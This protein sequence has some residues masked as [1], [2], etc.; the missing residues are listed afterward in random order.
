MEN[1]WKAGDFERRKSGGILKIIYTF[2][3]SGLWS[4]KQR[5]WVSVRDTN[6][7]SYRH[8][9]AAYKNST[10][11]ERVR[12]INLDHGFFFLPCCVFTRSSLSFLLCA[13]VCVCFFFF[14][15]CFVFAAVR[16]NTDLWAAL[17]RDHL[18]IVN[19]RSV[20]NVF[21]KSPLDNTET[22]L[23]DLQPA[24]YTRLRGN[25]L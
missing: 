3:R 15:F 1:A 9:A 12:G 6:P 18:P 14:L 24:R 5:G 23:S 22:D 13:C 11:V 4:L 16:T 17:I 21:L 2:F 20:K 7:I 8:Y 19:I 25:L 10:V